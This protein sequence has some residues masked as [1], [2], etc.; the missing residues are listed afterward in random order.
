[1][2]GEIDDFVV[3]FSE[4]TGSD[5]A[6]RSWAELQTKLEQTSKDAKMAQIFL[7]EVFLL[8]G[9]SQHAASLSKKDQN[10]VAHALGVMGKQTSL[11]ASNSF[12]ITQSDICPALLAL[13]DKAT[14]VVTA[15]EQASG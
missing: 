14:P 15:Q 6:H 4:Q 2:L 13:K 1:M 8:K 5:G 11:I 10:G 9:L 3:S 7:I 12:G